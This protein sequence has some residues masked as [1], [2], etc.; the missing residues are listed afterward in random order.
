MKYTRPM[1]TSTRNVM[2]AVKSMDSNKTDPQ[3]IDGPAS[4]GST[5]GYEADE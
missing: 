1:I 2:L 5:A 3:V 4:L